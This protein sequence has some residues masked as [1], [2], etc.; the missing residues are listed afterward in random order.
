MGLDALK[1]SMIARKYGVRA[2]LQGPGSDAAFC[3]RM[4]LESAH[5]ATVKKGSGRLPSVHAATATSLLREAQVSIRSVVE[6]FSDIFL[7]QDRQS[8]GIDA[9]FSRNER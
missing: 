2:V 9:Q 5:D 1:A 3:D 6:V 4:R 7:E 8:Y